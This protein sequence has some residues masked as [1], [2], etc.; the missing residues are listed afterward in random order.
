MNSVNS[1]SKKC[2]IFHCKLSIHAVVAH[3][4]TAIKIYRYINI[5]YVN[6]QMEVKTIK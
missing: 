2:R 1:T 5:K 3:Q 4:L 6:D